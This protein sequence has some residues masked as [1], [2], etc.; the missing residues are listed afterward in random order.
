M[1]LLLGFGVKS[2]A[3]DVHS[4]DGQN[5]WNETDHGDVLDPV[6]ENFHREFFVASETFPN[7]HF[8]HACF[9]GAASAGEVVW[10]EP[11][12]ADPA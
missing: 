8:I 1:V 12:Q 5:E 4:D 10:N 7:A 2:S 3:E 6:S 9:G 11:S